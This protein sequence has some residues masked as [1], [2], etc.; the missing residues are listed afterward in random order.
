MGDNSRLFMNI[1]EWLSE[2]FITA[3]SAIL[4]LAIVSTAVFAV[5][6]VFYL[7]KKLR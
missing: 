1:M 7:F 5:G 4:P 6:V 2:D 3:P